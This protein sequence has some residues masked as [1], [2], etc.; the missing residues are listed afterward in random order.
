M[1][2]T[3]LRLPPPALGI[4]VSGHPLPGAV[5]L[6]EELACVMWSGAGALSSGDLGFH[7]PFSSACLGGRVGWGVDQLLNLS[8]VHFLHLCKM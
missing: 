8:E 3:E 7:P 4:R 2:T 5:V 6:G 1:L